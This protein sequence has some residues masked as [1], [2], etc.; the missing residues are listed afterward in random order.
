M[1][2]LLIPHSTHVLS[3]AVNIATVNTFGLENSGC[4][5]ENGF[6][7]M[8]MD[9]TGKKFLLPKGN[10]ENVSKEVKNTTTSFQYNR[11]WRHLAN[12]KSGFANE[13]FCMAPHFFSFFQMMPQRK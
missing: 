3:T 13:L 11:K 8:Y 6:F 10:Q 2:E 7:S 1:E 5:S 12:E 4:S 9:W